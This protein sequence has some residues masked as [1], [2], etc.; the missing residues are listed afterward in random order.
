MFLLIGV[1][2]IVVVIDR[3]TKLWVMHTM[4]LGQS[5]VLI[6]NIFYLTYI[7]NPGAAFGILDRDNPHILNPFFYVIT[8]LATLF[9]FVIQRFIPYDQKLPRISL[10]M[11]WGGALGNFMDRFLYG[12]VV[13]FIDIGYKIYRWPVFNIADSCISVGLVIFIFSYM[14]FKKDVD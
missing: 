9:I 13:D 6:H 11:I 10:G 7:Q 1:A 2:L 14:F 12:K 4:H 8:V 5:I 3:I